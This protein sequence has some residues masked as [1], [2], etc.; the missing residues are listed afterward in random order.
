VLYSKVERVA[1]QTIPSLSRPILLLRREERL[2]YPVVHTWG[3]G[4]PLPHLGE[5][6]EEAVLE[7]P[8]AEAGDAGGDVR[9]DAVGELRGAVAVEVV[10]EVRQHLLALRRGA[11]RGVGRRESI[12][13]GWTV[14][15][16]HVRR[17]LGS[18]AISEDESQ[19][20]L[21]KFHGRS[22]RHQRHGTAS[23]TTVPLPAHSSRVPPRQRGARPYRDVVLTP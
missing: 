1:G 3:C 2:P 7:L 18:E 12:L 20:G 14:V 10:P 13:G 8:K 19:V 5:R 17:F 15:Q 22:G 21:H 9:L 16:G 11:F 23:R 6:G 4:R